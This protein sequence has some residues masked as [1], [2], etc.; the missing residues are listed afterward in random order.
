MASEMTKYMCGILDLDIVSEVY[1]SIVRCNL[2]SGK[3]LRATCH[4]EPNTEINTNNQKY[5]T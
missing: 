4:A 2:S 5:S 3:A 1:Q